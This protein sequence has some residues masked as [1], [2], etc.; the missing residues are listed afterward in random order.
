MAANE[1]VIL[2]LWYERPGGNKMAEVTNLSCSPCSEDEFLVFD[3]ISAELL[4]SCAI[5]GR[6]RR[7]SGADLDAAG[8][9]QAA[10]VW[11]DSRRGKVLVRWGRRTLHFWNFGTRLSQLES[12]RRPSEDRATTVRSSRGSV[13][14]D[15]KEDLCAYADEEAEREQRRQLQQTFALEGMSEEEMLQLAQVLS[16]GGEGSAHPAHSARSAQGPQPGASDAEDEYQL[17]LAM[18]LSLSELHK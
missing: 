15:L 5:P 9:V 7:V 17:Q 1:H 8:R 4:H 12:R 6:I 2:V 10:F 14:R 13:A 18:T 16:L 3:A 11:V